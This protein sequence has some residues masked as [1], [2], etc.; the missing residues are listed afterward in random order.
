MNDKNDFLFKNVIS[1]GGIMELNDANVR[2]RNKQINDGILIHTC[3][4]YGNSLE[5]IEKA[6]SDTDDLRVMLK[7]YFNYPDRK[8]RRNRPI[9]KQIE[10]ALKRIGRIPTEFIL[11]FCCYFDSNIFKEK[12][13]RT[14]LLELK[15]DYNIKTIYFEYYPVYNYNW[16]LFLN[17]QKNVSSI[18]IGVTGYQ[19]LFNRVFNDYD[20]KTLEALNIPIASIGFLGKNPKRDKN[21]KEYLEQMK[22]NDVDDIDLNFLYLIRNLTK[23]KNAKSFGITQV[24]SFKNYE[25]LKHRF[26]KYNNQAEE[27]FSYLN[28]T[29]DLNKNINLIRRDQYGGKYFFIDFIMNPKLLPHIIKKRALHYKTNTYYFS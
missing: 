21:P 26:S 6:S 22:I 17:L 10:E 23:M 13:F 15:R 3:S 8:N 2:L 14:F 9:K 5:V 16:E 29:I 27:I 18:N 19:N 24:S 4:D 25:N 28:N 11:Q 20:M 12:T 7:V 1:L